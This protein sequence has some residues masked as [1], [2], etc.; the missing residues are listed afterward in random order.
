ML[1]EN[2]P[3]CEFAREIFPL[4]VPGNVVFQCFLACRPR[5]LPVERS[6]LSTV[7]SLFPGVRFHR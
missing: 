5:D 7:V 4:N 2:V 1:D 3:A 6:V